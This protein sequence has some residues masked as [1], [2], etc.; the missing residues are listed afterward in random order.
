MTTTPSAMR[1]PAVLHSWF[2]PELLMLLGAALVLVDL[3]LRS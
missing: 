1:K 2:F 3:L